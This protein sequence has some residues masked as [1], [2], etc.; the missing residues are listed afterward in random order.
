MTMS[1]V[2]GIARCDENRQNYY[3]AFQFGVEFKE[4]YSE[5]QPAP[6]PRVYTDVPSKSQA[7]NQSSII[8]NVSSR[9][10]RKCRLPATKP[11]NNLSPAGKFII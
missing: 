11:T 4:L 9:A 3:P 6:S 10:F 2:R 1:S 7:G 5:F 8:K